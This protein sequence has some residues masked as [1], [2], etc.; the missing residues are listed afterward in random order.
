MTEDLRNVPQVTFRGPNKRFP[1]GIYLTEKG[2][3]AI[4]VY[5]TS[6]V[7]VPLIDPSYWPRTKRD[8]PEAS[9]TFTKE[10]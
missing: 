8:R 4:G 2:L 7:L 3:N 9:R 10:T 5:K 6:V 1:R